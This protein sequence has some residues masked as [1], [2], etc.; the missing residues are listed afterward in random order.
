MKF[1]KSKINISKVG[2]H[3]YMS[4]YENIL[5]E[6]VNT[7]DPFYFGVIIEITEEGKYTVQEENGYI[8]TWNFVYPCEESEPLIKKFKKS[9]D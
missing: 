7:S 2:E 3:V 6:H 4:D 8:F 1:D 9:L 5:E